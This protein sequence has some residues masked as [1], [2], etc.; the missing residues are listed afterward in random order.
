MTNLHALIRLFS[1][2]ITALLVCIG[3]AVGSDH[4]DPIDPLNRQRQEGGITDL[5]VFPVLK[6][7]SPA[8]PYSGNATVP[9]SGSMADLARTP[10]TTAQQAQIDSIVVVDRKS[11]V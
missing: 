1:V 10:M 11:V 2:T 9:I 3:I 6:D 8:F 4:A 5:F 7:Q